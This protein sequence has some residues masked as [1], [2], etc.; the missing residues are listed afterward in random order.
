[1][2]Y[3]RK[4][5]RMDNAAFRRLNHTGTLIAS[6]ALTHLESLG[7]LRR[8]EQ[9]RGPGVHYTLVEERETPQVTPH[10]TPQGIEE[11]PRLLAEGR[12]LSREEMADLIVALCAERPHTARELAQMLHRNA[13]YLRDAYLS[14]LVREGRPQLTGAPND[15]NVAYRA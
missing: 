11:L 9:R 8:S 5:G 1:M 10:T 4:T 3:A 13:K 6:R 15:P 14:P 2:V 12:R 7:L